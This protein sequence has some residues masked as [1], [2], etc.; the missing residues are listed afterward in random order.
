M[1]YRSETHHKDIS[2][3]C[4]QKSRHK[5]SGVSIVGAIFLIT[6]LAVL[7]TYLTRLTTVGNKV[8]IN[9]WL[10][11]QALYSAES[12]VDWAA[13]NIIHGGTGSATDSV[14][15]NNSWFSTAVSTTSYGGRTLYVINSTGT[16]GTDPATPEVQR[17]I[18]VQ[19][20]P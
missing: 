11:A 4:R 7:G 10:S 15:D 12:G 5:Q 14:I 2:A 3:L 19:F 8:V 13:Y 16:A 6:G 9:E 20:L 17:E 18:E 1:R